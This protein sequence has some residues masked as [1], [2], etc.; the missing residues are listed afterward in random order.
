MQL[1]LPLQFGKTS[2]GSSTPQTTLLDVCSVGFWESQ[3]LYYQSQVSESGQTQVFVWDKPEQLP[4]ALR[5]LNISEFP[6]GGAESSSLQSILERQEDWLRRSHPQIIPWLILA[7]ILIQS[8]SAITYREG[9]ILQLTTY[10]YL[11]NDWQDYQQRYSLS[12]KCKDGI[13]RRSQGNKVNL[14]EVLKTA[15]EE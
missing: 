15:L 12:R 1:I 11:A 9:L 6:K 13:L 7:T 5:M 8:K 4:G 10:S 3:N 2:Q 14:P